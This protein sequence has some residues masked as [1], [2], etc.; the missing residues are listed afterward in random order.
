MLPALREFHYIVWRPSRGRGSD[1]SAV[2]GPWV[3][4]GGTLWKMAHEHGVLSP[5]TILSGYRERPPA[6]TPPPEATLDTGWLG[7][8]EAPILSGA[9]F[10]LAF[11]GTS[12]AVAVALPRELLGALLQAWAQ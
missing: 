12:T 8:L 7:A 3:T 1:A 11:P 6:S 5:D 2:P 4:T 10:E 9:E